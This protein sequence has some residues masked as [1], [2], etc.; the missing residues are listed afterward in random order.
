[1]MKVFI[2]EDSATMLKELQS[3][4]S[5][6]PGVTVVGH[7]VDEAGAIERINALHPD[8]VTLDLRL[9]TGSG[10]DVLKNVKKHHAGIKVVVLTNCTKEAYAKYCMHVGADHF[11]DKSFQYVQFRDVLRELACPD[12]PGNR[13]DPLQI[14]GKLP[15][16]SYPTNSV[17]GSYGHK[18]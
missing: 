10:I 15:V 2:V 7:A 11:F 14:S 3:T 4:L 17:T 12:R 13:L 18:M 8:V 6:I 5:G 1:M 9:E 16:A